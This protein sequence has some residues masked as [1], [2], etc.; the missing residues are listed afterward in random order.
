LAALVSRSLEAMLFGVTPQDA[1]VL[2]ATVGILAASGIAACL[3]P[4]R[5]AARVDPLVVL[6]EE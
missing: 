5:R 4:A 2:V 6:R 3:V 1:T